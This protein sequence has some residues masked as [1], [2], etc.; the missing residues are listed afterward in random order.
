MVRCQFG[1]YVYGTNVPSSDTDIKGIFIPELRDIILQRAPKQHIE[2]TKADE[3]KRNTKDDVDVELFALHQFMKLIRDGQTVALD[4][5]NID[6]SSF[7][8]APLLFVAIVKH[9]LRNMVL[10]EVGFL[11][12]EM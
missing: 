9:R 12:L 4:L 5:L 6:K 11:L 10:R 8:L 3:T 2:K 7:I 1:S